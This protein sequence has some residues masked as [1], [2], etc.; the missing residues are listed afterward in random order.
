MVVVSTHPF[1]KKNPLF[2]TEKNLPQVSGV[3]LSGKYSK[4]PMKSFFHGVMN[5]REISSASHPLVI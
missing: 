2:L 4:P 3:K 5:G 1:E